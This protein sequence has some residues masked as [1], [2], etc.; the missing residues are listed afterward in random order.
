[1]CS[2]GYMAAQNGIVFT[3][4]NLLLGYGIL[5]SKLLLS[6]AK[7]FLASS[8]VICSSSPPTNF[9]WLSCRSKED[10]RSYQVILSTN[11]E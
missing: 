9:V 1:M 4:Y 3:E 5:K 11:K 8:S 7:N 2:L 10:I 6:F